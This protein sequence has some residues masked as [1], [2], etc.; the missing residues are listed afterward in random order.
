MVSSSIE[1][2]RILLQL[3]KKIP[4]QSQLSY[5]YQSNNFKSKS[6]DWFLYHANIFTV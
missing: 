1:I 6:I 3:N 2:D 4:E 5:R